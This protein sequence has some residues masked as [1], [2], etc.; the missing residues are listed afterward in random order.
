MQNM[1]HDS[2]IKTTEHGVKRELCHKEGIAV[3]PLGR[4]C[5]C[6]TKDYIKTAKKGKGHVI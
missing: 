6:F 5:T 4:L 1:N 3:Q 2:T